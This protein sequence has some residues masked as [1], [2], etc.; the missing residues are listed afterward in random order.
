MLTFRR[1]DFNV[2]QISGQ[3]K[4][5]KLRFC[6]KKVRKIPFSTNDIFFLV[7]SE[8]ALLVL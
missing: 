8:Y 2:A 1:A 4:V 6:N 7:T 3:K 5:R